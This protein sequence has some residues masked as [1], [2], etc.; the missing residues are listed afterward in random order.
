MSCVGLEPTIP[1]FEREKTFHALG[2]TATVIVSGSS[3]RCSVEWHNPKRNNRHLEQTTAPVILPTNDRITRQ[4]MRYI[5]AYI[6]QQ[7]RC[8]LQKNTVSESCHFTKAVLRGNLKRVLFSDVSEHMH[9]WGG[10][11]TGYEHYGPVS[12]PGRGKISLFSTASR[13]SLRLTQPPNQLIPREI[14]PGIKQLGREAHHSPPFRAEV[15][16]TWSY[17]S[18][19]PTLSLRGA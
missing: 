4:F 18:A 11:A 9:I 8:Q 2:S 19:I 13:L 7:Y 6:P 10:I 3:S 5:T 12:I 1:A 15:K 17:A 14:S 16:T